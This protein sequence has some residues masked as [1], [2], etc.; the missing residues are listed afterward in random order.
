MSKAKSIKELVSNNDKR[1]Y[2]FLSDKETVA[3][4]VANAEAEG[5]K[6]E[7]GVNP[8]ERQPSNFYALNRNNTINYINFIGRIAFQCN[9]GH[10]VRV[11]YKKYISG[12]EEYY[13]G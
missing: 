9:A 2:V 10:I 7:D 4:F 11:D 6:F 13:Y 3:R 5:Y 8:S 12:N 1:V